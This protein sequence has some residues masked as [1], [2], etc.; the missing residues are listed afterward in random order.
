ML[1]W[2]D[3]MSKSSFS[4]IFDVKTI[5]LTGLLSSIAIVLAF[6]EGLL[7]DFPFVMPGMKLGLSNIVIMFSLE[8]L[9]LPCTL[10]TVIFKALFAIVTRG[11]T[12]GIMSLSGGMLS[13]FIMFFLVRSKKLRFG[14]LGIGV[15]GAFAH[16]MGQLLVAL[17]IVSDAVYGYFPVLCVT[18][19]VTGTLTG[20]ANYFILPAIKKIPM[21]QER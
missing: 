14:S 20:I 3:A 9:P 6:L 2:G 10:V 19:V 1:L 15:A 12:A 17:A 13:A 7:P 21:M 18:S 16:N 4:K 8:V 11:M 5:A